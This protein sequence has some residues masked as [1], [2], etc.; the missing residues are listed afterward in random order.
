MILYK[1]LLGLNDIQVLYFTY[2]KHFEKKKNNLFLMFVLEIENNSCS[3]CP[4]NYRLTMKEKEK[5]P[6]HG[7]GIQV[8]QKNAL[9]CSKLIPTI[10]VS[11][12]GPKLHPNVCHLMVQFLLK[13]DLPVITCPIFP[14]SS[15]RS[16]THFCFSQLSLLCQPSCLPKSSSAGLVSNPIKIMRYAPGC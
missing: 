12:D 8:F 10:S 5:C 3:V 14:V 9:E 2:L 6:V 1:E 11:S 16:V 13:F 15:T 4:Y 7:S